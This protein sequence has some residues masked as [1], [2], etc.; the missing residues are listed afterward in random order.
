MLRFAQALVMASRS[1]VVPDL[2][3]NLDSQPKPWQPLRQAM[4]AR[5]ASFLH[6]F[7]QFCTFPYLT[8]DCFSSSW[9]RSRTD[10]SYFSLPFSSIWY[11]GGQPSRCWQGR[12][13]VKQGIR[14]RELQN[15]PAT[16]SGMGQ[17]GRQRASVRGRN[18]RA[19]ARMQ[20]LSPIF[21]KSPS[22][23]S[24]WAVEGEV[25]GEL[26]RVMVHAWVGASTRNGCHSRPIVA[27]MDS[28]AYIFWQAIR[29]GMAISK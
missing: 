23:N 10:F 5:D 9:D 19:G 1:W 12:F 21:T 22:T 8:P 11:R 16:I 20:L 28:V 26:H 4:A 3:G 13:R 14:D 27:E 18:F 6:S 15:L 25:S 24:G 17:P 2:P 29:W 7:D